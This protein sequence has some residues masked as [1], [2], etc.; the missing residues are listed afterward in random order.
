MLSDCCLDIRVDA[1]FLA[2]EFVDDQE[3][4]TEVAA[5]LDQV[6][7]GV[8]L[9]QWGFFSLL[10]I[11]MIALLSLIGLVPSQAVHAARFIFDFCNVRHSLIALLCQGH[12][13]KNNIFLRR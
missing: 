12:L 5:G 3:E 11:V 1:L 8:R 10:F 9:D 7:F 6:V 4:G 13:P 2:V